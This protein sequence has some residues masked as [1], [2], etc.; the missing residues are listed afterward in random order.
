MVFQ[1]VSHHIGRRFD[2]FEMLTN[3]LGVAQTK[4]GMSL[5]Q[6]NKTL[7]IGKH[8]RITF[9]I[10]PVKLVNGVGRTK[11]IVHTFLVAQHLFATKH[12][13]NTLRSEHKR[14]RQEV[15]LYQFGSGYARYRVAYAVG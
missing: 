14:L 13:R 9:E 7:V 12:E 1:A 2:K 3:Q 10:G 8:L 5:A 6:G 11:T 4:R 15:E